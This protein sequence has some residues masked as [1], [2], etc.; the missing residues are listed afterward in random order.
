MVKLTFAVRGRR[1][2]EEF[3]PQMAAEERRCVDG[4]VNP[5]LRS[6]AAIC[7]P[8]SSRIDPS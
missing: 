3:G 8:N 5:D 4:I 6:S 2:D 1:S 7:G